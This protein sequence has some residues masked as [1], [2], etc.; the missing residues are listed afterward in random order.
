MNDPLTGDKTSDV[1]AS[2][3]ADQLGIEV[4][5]VAPDAVITDLGADSLDVV[6]IRM[7]L[8]DEFGIEISEAEEA[9]IT[10][11]QSAVNLVDRKL[12]AAAIPRSGA[13]A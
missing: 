8:E 4:S 13:P 6:E 2:M 3:I 12:H 10:T 9:A 5:R 7:R 1:V 11:V